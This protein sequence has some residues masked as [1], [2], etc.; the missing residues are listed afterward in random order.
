MSIQDLSHQLS[1]LARRYAIGWKTFEQTEWLDAA[2]VILAAA[3]QHERDE[4]LREAARKHCERCAEDCEDGIQCVDGHLCE[5]QLAV[6]GPERAAIL[7]DQPKDRKDED[8]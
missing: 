3:L 5:E 4:A 2:N 6:F 8:A 7:A 1:T